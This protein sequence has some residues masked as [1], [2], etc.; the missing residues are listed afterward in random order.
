M[1]RLAAYLG[2]PIFLD[3]VIVKPRNSLLSQSRECTMASQRTQGD[4]WGLGWY[5][6]RAEPGLLRDYAPAWND[7]NLLAAAQALRS[8]LFM[9]HVRAATAGEVM[10]TNCHPFAHGSWMF[11][12][13]GGI[14]GFPQLRRTLESWLDDELFA[15]RRGSTDSELLFLLILRMLRQGMPPPAAGLAVFEAVGALMKEHKV[16]APLRFAAVLADGQRL[17]AFRL[18]SDDAPPSLY[19]RRMSGSEAVGPGHKGLGGTVVAS[20]PLCGESRGWTELPAGAVVAV[21][22]HGPKVVRHRG[23]PPENAARPEPGTRVRPRASARPGAEA[24]PKPP[25]GKPEIAVDLVL[26]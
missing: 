20:E 18:A 19:L 14:G 8:H 3:D 21:D 7:S 6:E 15:A 2:E 24:A 5:G 22:A 10:R 23:S 17:W 25:R 16:E 1:C 11:M 9:A 4:G 12:H 13:N 26:G